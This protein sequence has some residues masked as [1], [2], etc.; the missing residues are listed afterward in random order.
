MSISRRS[1]LKGSAAAAALGAI[2]S[3]SVSGAVAVAA[4]AASGVAAVSGPGDVVGKVTVGYQGWFAAL[5]DG[6]PINGWWHWSQNWSQ[7]PSPTNAGI[8]AWPDMHDYT[9]TYPTNFAPLHSGATATLFSDYDQDTV[10]AQ[11]AWMQ[12]N[13]ID[14]VALQRFNPDSSEGP[15]R[16]AMATKV[17]TAAETYGRKFYIMYDVSGWTDMQSQMKTDWTSKMSALTAS[18]A[19]AKQN[20]KPV[21][22]IWGFGFNDD[23]RPFSADVC[24]DVVAWFKSQ[25]VYLI[26]GVPTHWRTGESVRPNFLDVFHQFNMLSPWMIGAMSTIQQADA[27]AVDINAADKADCD[28]HGIDYQPCVM[29]GDLSQRERVH[30]NYMWRQFY[31]LANLGVAGFYISMFDE[32]NEGH[33]IAKTAATQADVPSNSSYLSLDEDGTPCSSD[34]YLRLTG[35]GGRMLKGTLALTP[36]RPTAPTVG[37]NTGVATVVSFTARV[38]NLIVTADSAGTA[39]LIANRTAVGQWEQFDMVNAGNGDIALLAHANGKYVTAENAGAQ[40]LIANRTAVGQWETFRIVIQPGTNGAVALL[41]RAN[42][43]YVTASNA[44]QGPLIA[45]ATQVGGWEQFDITIS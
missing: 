15:T 33:Q 2:G 9:H 31:N 30:G 24:A 23:S 13:A 32:Y 37:S 26:G 25:G 4:P 22:C 39:P 6:A 27:F 21:V 45:S 10:N 19:Y 41:S 5:G 43:R 3:P 8:R 28:A 7:P 42:G 35:D 11:F 17:R 20:G 34:Y 38:N 40:P 14:T 36:V 29:P 1:F 44:G 18:P 12:Q 16:D